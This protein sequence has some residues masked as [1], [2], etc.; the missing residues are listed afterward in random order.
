MS[1]QEKISVIVVRVGQEPVIEE[2]VPELSEFQRLVGGSI[3]GWGV[4]GTELA[5]YCRSDG[6]YAMPPNRLIKG[7]DLLHGNF[8]VARANAAGDEVSLK[9]GDLEA[10]KATFE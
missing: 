10:L 3:E 2:I 4:P 5:L 8:V 7:L 6:R 1:D 9:P